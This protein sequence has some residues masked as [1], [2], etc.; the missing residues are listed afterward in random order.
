MAEKL[1]E[2]G[3]EIREKKNVLLSL[4][5]I[6]HGERTLA[7]EL[8]DYGRQI[9][10]EIARAEQSE[11]F[12]GV[13]AVG[14]PAGPKGP[15]GMPRS[16]ET[17][18]IYAGEVAKKGVKQYKTRVREGLGYQT[19]RTKEPFN[20]TAYYNEVAEKSANEKFG[21]SFGELADREKAEAAD[22][23]ETAAVN[24]LLA[25]RNAEDF[26][27]EVAGRFSLLFDRYIR[28]ADRL[29]NDSRVLY[30]AGTHGGLIEPFLR[31]VMVRRTADGKEIHGFK[32]INEIGGAFRPSEAFNINVEIDDGGQ[33]RVTLTFDDRGRGKEGEMCTVDLER[34]EEL[35]G[36]YKKLYGEPAHVRKD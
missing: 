31:E 35:A 5:V 1:F 4:K 3:A 16:L 17:A 13:K 20:W 32:D 26:I 2:K 6:R 28:M 19:L 34:L 36:E 21:K 15:T 29:K 14:S 12:G 18:H 25:D 24:K 10:R 22:V 30:I 7:G 11:N 27:R 9:T 23:A 33:K 8:T